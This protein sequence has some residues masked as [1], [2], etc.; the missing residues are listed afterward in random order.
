LLL[1]TFRMTQVFG[2]PGHGLEAPALVGA[3]DVAVDR[4]PAV[5]VPAL[6]AEH[7][8]ARAARDVIGA[9]SHRDDP[10]PLLVPAQVLPDLEPAP[11][12]V[13]MPDTDCR[14]TSIKDADGRVSGIRFRIGDG[15]RDMKK[16]AP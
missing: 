14:F 16:I 6:R 8:A 7:L 10:P 4:D 1:A 12:D 15:E 9:I 3:G 11:V 13:D 5:A 2:F